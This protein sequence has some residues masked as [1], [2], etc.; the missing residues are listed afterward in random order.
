MEII[1]I[2]P[3]K[4]EIIEQ[5]ILLEIFVHF[6]RYQYFVMNYLFYFQKFFIIL[7]FKKTKV[8]CLRNNKINIF[9]KNKITFY[10][11]CLY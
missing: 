3:F 1:I 7:I 5:F 11:L 10:F 9:Y 8:Y 4:I 2:D 6:D